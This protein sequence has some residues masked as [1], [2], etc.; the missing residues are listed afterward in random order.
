MFT[1]QKEPEKGPSFSLSPELAKSGNLTLLIKK[2]KFNKTIQNENENRPKEIIKRKI[3][4]I[5]L[6]LS[7]T[8]KNKGQ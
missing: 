3:Q 1:N 6:S 8:P 2:F 5:D 4:A 7:P